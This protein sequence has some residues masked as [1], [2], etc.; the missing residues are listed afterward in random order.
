L[1]VGGLAGGGGGAWQ[2]GHVEARPWSCSARPE[3]AHGGLAADV[4][5]DDGNSPDGRAA[6]TISGSVEARRP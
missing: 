6:P 1:A 3:V 2:L 4:G 5:G